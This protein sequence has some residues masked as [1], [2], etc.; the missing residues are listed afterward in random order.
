MANQLIQSQGN[1]NTAVLLQKKQYIKT[2]NF[3]NSPGR[4]FSG[5]GF[6][7]SLSI[8]TLGGTT[9]RSTNSLSKCSLAPAS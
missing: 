6:T 2:K 3:Q 1:D 5:F 9:G 7:S 4:R 8:N